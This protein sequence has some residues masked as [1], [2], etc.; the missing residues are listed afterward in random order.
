[1]SCCCRWPNRWL[2]W[3][4]QQRYE[5]A[6]SVRDEAERLRHLMERQRGIDSLR[7][8]GRMTLE[9]VGEGTVVLEAGLLVGGPVGGGAI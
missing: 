8:A 5:E 6:A 4:E 2:N 9:I 7:R 1:M 3:P